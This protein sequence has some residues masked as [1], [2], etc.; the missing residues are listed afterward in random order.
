MKLIDKLAWIEIK[1]QQILGTRTKGKDI[2]Y[3]P[4]GKREPGESDAAA[5]IREIREELD[6]ELIP[7]SIEFM[8]IFEEQAHGHD[9]GIIVKMQCYTAKYEGQLKPSAEIA[10]M[11]WLN[12]S[13]MDI[14]SA[15][16]R[17]IFSWLKAKD[18][19]E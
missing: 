8:G 19:I 2:F 16:D 13:H 6:V 10:E 3:I 12:T 1:D 17:V 9:E 14:I 18:W 11:R 5:L 4:G 15:V 7:D